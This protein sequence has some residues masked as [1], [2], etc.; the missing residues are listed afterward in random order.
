M[1]WAMTVIPVVAHGNGVAMQD[2][3]GV[4]R[5]MF[6]VALRKDAN[7]DHATRLAHIQLGRQMA[8]LEELVPAPAPLARLV[9][10]RCRHRG[11]VL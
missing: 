3:A 1:R 8:R 11:V 5:R 4:A 10:K 9:A 6:A 2:R 7:A